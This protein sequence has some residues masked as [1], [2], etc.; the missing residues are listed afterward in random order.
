M[1]LIYLFIYMSLFFKQ[2]YSDDIFFY[3]GCVIKNVEVLIHAEKLLTVKTTDG[4]IISFKNPRIKN[5]EKK[6]IIAYQKSLLKGD[7]IRMDPINIAWNKQF[8]SLEKRSSQIQSNLYL[9]PISFIAAGLIYDSIDNILDLN[10]TIEDYVY[11][12]FPEKE[13]NRLKRERTKYY[14]LGTVY[15]ICGTLN[16]VIALRKFEINSEENK[17]NLSFKF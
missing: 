3:G 11:D 7:C 15:L 16:T 4:Q 17:L 10:E 12:D 2:S 6:E 5:I 9:L 13:I 8:E 14:I 1:K